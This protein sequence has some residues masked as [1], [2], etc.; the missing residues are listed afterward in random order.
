MAFISPETK[1]VLER[2]ANMHDVNVTIIS[3]RHLDDL[4]MKVKLVTTSII[5]LTLITR[6][7]CLPGWSGG[8]H[9]RRLPWIG[10]PTP[11]WQG[12]QDRLM[13]DLQ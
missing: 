7:S 4:K 12:K 5:P 1:K 3:G 8:Y 13:M 9:L 10:N 6:Q 2:L 11:G